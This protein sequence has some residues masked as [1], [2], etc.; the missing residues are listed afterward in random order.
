[1]S[2][3]GAPAKLVRAKNERRRRLFPIAASARAG[4]D[5]A[6]RRGWLALAFALSLC[7][8]QRGEGDLGP[9]AESRTPASL[10]GRFYPPDGWAWG[11]LQLGDGPVQ[12]YGV[13]AAPGTPRAEVLILP[14]YGETAETWFETARDLNARGYTVWVLEGVGQG[15]SER[16]AAPRDLGHVKRFRPDA[17]AARALARSVIRPRR[18][19]IVVGQGIGA[20]TALRATQLGLAADGLVLSSPAL[21][22]AREST[23]DLIRRLGLGARRAAG[24][25]WSRER[26]AF[27]A[28]LT[29]DPWRGAV[30]SAWQ[31]AN[32]DLRMGDPSYDWL[33][34]EVEAVRE[35]RASLGRVTTPVLVLEGA[36]G[37]GCLTLP[38]CQAVRYAAGGRALE[39]ERDVVREPWLAA[40]S[41]FIAARAARSRPA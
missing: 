29:H 25:G 17:L 31:T 16:L 36:D 41:A 26:S 39:L 33:A 23:G 1:M 7:A 18:P 4:E 32:P 14:D 21:A 11:F 35:A 30:T 12:R 27:A 15:G 3:I 19:L 24:G 40:V 8:C 9:F 20:L 28:K 10:G 37:Q 5:E 34:A 13:S 38:T 2:L 22:P 6:M